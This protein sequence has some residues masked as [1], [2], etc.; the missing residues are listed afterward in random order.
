MKARKSGDLEIRILTAIVDTVV[1]F[2]DN[3]P[4]NYLLKEFIGCLSSVGHDQN[5][6]AKCDA[7]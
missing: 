1:E 2:D 6:A 3:R 4:A 5:S 7:F